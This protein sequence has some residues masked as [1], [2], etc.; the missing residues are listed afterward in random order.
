MNDYCQDHTAHSS[1][2]NT[3]KETTRELKQDIEGMGARISA[4]VKSKVF[5]SIVGLFVMAM[6]A[7]FTKQD[8]VLSVVN[9]INVNQRLTQKDIETI[10]GHIEDLRGK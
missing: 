4:R 8:K 9:E 1:Q 5:W 3:N 6:G 2:I 7:I 10:Q